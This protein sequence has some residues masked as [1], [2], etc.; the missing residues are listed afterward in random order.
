MSTTTSRSALAVSHWKAGTNLVI[1]LLQA[2]GYACM[3]AGT[4]P[5]PGTGMRPEALQAFGALEATGRL[6]E[7]MCFFL[8]QLPMDDIP[9]P[10]ARKLSM[11]ENRPRV[12]YNYRDPRAVLVPPSTTCD[13]CLR[14][15]ITRATSS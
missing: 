9:L 1:R 6:P 14:R 4:G 10:L 2:A 13:A 7:D 5:E 12:V 8:H 15:T 3:G 11:D